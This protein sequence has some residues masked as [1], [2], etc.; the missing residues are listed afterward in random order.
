MPEHA[1]WNGIWSR[2]GMRTLTQEV[3]NGPKPQIRK[4][5]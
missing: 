5:A 2:H 4:D 3:M 1:G